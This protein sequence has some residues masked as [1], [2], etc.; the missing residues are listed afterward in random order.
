MEGVPLEVQEN[1]L[2]QISQG[3]GWMLTEI[4]IVFAHL[5]FGFFIAFLVILP[6]IGLELEYFDFSLRSRS[7]LIN[8]EDIERNIWVVFEMFYG[9]TSSVLQNIVMSIAVGYL[10]F[11]YMGLLGYY[12]NF[13]ITVG[14]YFNKNLVHKF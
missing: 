10:V 9:E 1:A 5:L 2:R 3:R 8:G 7:N 14:D 11:F 12:W 4:L 13:Q 6:F